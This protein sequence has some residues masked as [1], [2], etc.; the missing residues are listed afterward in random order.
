MHL[1]PDHFTPPAFH[2]AGLHNDDIAEINRMLLRQVKQR[3]SDSYQQH[4][5]S[6]GSGLFNSLQKSCMVIQEKTAGIIA[7]ELNQP[8][9]HI[10]ER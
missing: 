1:L 2:A 7:R 3:K 9:S 10:N 8:V 6:C 5:Q 4:L